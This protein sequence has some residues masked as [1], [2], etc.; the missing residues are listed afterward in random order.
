MQNHPRYLV[1]AGNTSAT[2]GIASGIEP[3]PA[4]GKTTTP[5]VKNSH[6]EKLLERHGANTPEVWES[7][8]RNQGSVQHLPFLS[9][10]ERACFKTPAEI[11][12]L[13]AVSS[14][15]ANG[16]DKQFMA[17][18]YLL[19]GLMEHRADYKDALTALETASPYVS[20]YVNTGHA[21]PAY[22][23]NLLRAFALYPQLSKDENRAEQMARLLT[24]DFVAY[25]VAAPTEDLDAED[26]LADAAEEVLT[27]VF[28]K[29]EKLFISMQYFLL[30]AMVHD[31]SYR[32]AYDALLFA[33]AVHTGLRKDGK[34]PEFQ[35]QLEIA[36][37]LRTM[38]RSLIYP[39]E[40]LAASF[41]HD[42]PEDYD[43]PYAEIESRFGARVA[44]TTSLL[45]K[46]DEQGAPKPLRKY[47][48]ALAD[49]AM[50]SAIKP[51]DNG[52]NQSTMAAVFSYKKQFEYSLNIKNLSWEMMKVARRKWP[53]QEA[54][55]ENLKFLLRIQYNAVQAMLNAVQFDPVTGK[56][57]PALSA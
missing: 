57:H 49:D 44:K 1:S 9:Q 16:F 36:H 5:V 53:E 46:Y 21:E 2:G 20:A 14:I 19:L 48:M 45:N 52:H 29:F 3:M 23:V 26:K 25:P 55:Y 37:Y 54:V 41:L 24:P 28:G 8:F 31:D 4:G 50:G 33:S 27:P 32:I 22:Q 42:T 7:I 13:I 35:H 10:V 18:R 51:T 11:D 17:M 6:I 40:T 38:L 15:D 30:G 34:T 39:A 12:H 43:V 47:F 56:I